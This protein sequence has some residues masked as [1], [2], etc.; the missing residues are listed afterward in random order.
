MS[1]TCGICKKRHPNL[2]TDVAFGRPDPVLDLPPAHR[3]SRAK[4]SDDLCAIDGQVFFLR[5]LLMLP[6]VSEPPEYFGW[7]VWAHVSSEAFYRYVAL[8]SSDGSSE[9]PFSATL[10]SRI[11]GYPPTLGLPCH[12]QLRSPS[13]RPALTI[14][15]PDHL[16]FHEQAQGITHA[17]WH[18]LLQV[19]LPSLFT[20]PA[21]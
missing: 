10:A 11:P 21:A 17:R 14:V 4:E 2:P 3:Q 15:Q 16:L 18:S 5:G 12:V 7:G 6:S 13:Q 9:P 1:Y 8:W 19:A 20:D